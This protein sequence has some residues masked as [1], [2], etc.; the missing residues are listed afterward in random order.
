MGNEGAGGEGGGGEL[1]PMTRRLFDFMH[2]K[3]VG[4]LH[5]ARQALGTRQRGGQRGEG[6]EGGGWKP[7]KAPAKGKGGKALKQTGVQRRVA[8]AEA[9][10]GGVGGGGGGGGSGGM[11]TNAIF[12]TAVAARSAVASP[13]ILPNIS[14]IGIKVCAG[15]SFID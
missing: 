14:T 6:G 5:G 3:C 15:S 13:N 1:V 9:E 4:A 10:G 8:A 11:N 2:K 12:I 7:T